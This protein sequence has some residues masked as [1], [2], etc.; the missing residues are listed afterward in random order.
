M[1]THRLL[2]VVLFILKTLDANEAVRDWLLPA[3]SK[4]I[5]ATVVASVHCNIQMIFIYSFE[6]IGLPF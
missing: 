2:A 1:S 4:K 3:V 6:S 5:I